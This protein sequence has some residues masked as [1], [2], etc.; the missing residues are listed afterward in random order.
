M[1][2]A[3]F[4]PV[5]AADF[6]F[7]AA[8]C[9][10]AA[11]A[12]ALRFPRR[13]RVEQPGP[14]PFRPIAAPPIHG[15]VD[16]HQMLSLMTGVVAP[17]SLIL[18]SRFW[19]IKFASD[20]LREA[21]ASQLFLQLC[22]YLV[23]ALGQWP[24]RLAPPVWLTLPAMFGAARMRSLLGMFAACRADALF[25]RIGN[26]LGFA[27]IKWLFRRHSGAELMLTATRLA[28][29]GGLAATLIDCLIA[30]PLIEAPAFMDAR[31]VGHKPSLHEAL[32][33][34]VGRERT[35]KAD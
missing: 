7:V 8:V 30:L 28:A 21:V 17:V 25:P 3:V 16:Q 5:P 9:A 34:G 13:A 27:G 19:H 20:A 4:T 32:E 2:V 35:A 14:Y 24:A 26:S 22:Q 29:M 10:Y 33:P 1:L 12:T 18:A 6:V 23:E 15:F 11:L 31:Y